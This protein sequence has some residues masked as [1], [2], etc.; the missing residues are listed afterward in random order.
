M[1]FVVKVSYNCM[2]RMGSI[3]KQYNACICGAGQESGSQPRCCN[4]CKPERCPLN[5]HCLTNMIVVYKETV[6]TDG[7]RPP[8]IYV[9]STETSFKQCYA[10]HLM[11]FNARVKFSP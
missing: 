3:I 1:L 6:E 5:G 8:K 2:P 9:G 11:S 10:N 7:T 4:C